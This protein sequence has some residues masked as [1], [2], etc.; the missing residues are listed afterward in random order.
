ML[1][2]G[3]WQLGYLGKGTLVAPPGPV[4]PEDTSLAD[5]GTAMHAAKANAPDASDPWLSWV[6]PHRETLW[7]SRL[8]E[9]EVTVAYDCRHRTIELF[10]S[11]SEEARTAWKMS[12]NDDCL[13]GTADWWAEL[14]TGEPW[15]DDLKTGW[16]RIE[17]P[18]NPYMFYLL[19]RWI[20]GGRTWT[21]G[22]MSN[23]WWPR[24]KEPTEPDRKWLQ[25]SSVA[26]EA[27]E[28]QLHWAWARATGFNPEPR[29]GLHCSYCP[30]AGVCPRANDF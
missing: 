19:C 24:A 7:P 20:E 6:E 29:P 10:R 14:P 16:R 22:R 12:R 15:I 9:H 8:G 27:F 2:R 25:V 23:T 1:D 18:T 3:K 26:L 13:V 17:L 11:P 30:S 28:E 5:W 4:E 21:T